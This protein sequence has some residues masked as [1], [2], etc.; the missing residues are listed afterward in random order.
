[1]LNALRR[2]IEQFEWCLGQ[3]VNWEKFAL[4][5]VNMA[6]TSQLN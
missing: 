3:K 4:C 5:V 2:I 1:M 6:T